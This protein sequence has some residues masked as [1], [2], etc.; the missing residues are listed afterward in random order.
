[1]VAGPEF[2][3]KCGTGHYLGEFLFLNNLGPQTCKGFAA[4][5]GLVHV[6]QA[7]LPGAVSR[8]RSPRLRGGQGR[9]D[10]AL[11]PG[12]SSCL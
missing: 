1:M 5:A 9:V 3:L 12:V 4:R 7:A 8:S 6:E 11:P 2:M 10:P